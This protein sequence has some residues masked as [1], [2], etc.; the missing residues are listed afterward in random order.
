MSECNHVW[1]ESKR[2]EDIKTLPYSFGHL[3]INGKKSIVGV[4]FGVMGKECEKC[5][6]VEVF[7]RIVKES[8]EPLTINT[9]SLFPRLSLWQRFRNWLGL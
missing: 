1:G 8:E 3:E 6:A 7:T 2:I 5:S 4:S 9:I